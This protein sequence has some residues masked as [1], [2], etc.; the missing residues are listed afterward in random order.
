METKSVGLEIKTIDNL[1]LRRILNE[2]KGE[3]SFVKTPYQAII[4]KYLVT[5]QK[6]KVYQHTLEK[7][8]NLRRSTISGILDTMEKKGTI[9][10][11]NSNEDARSKLVVLTP[12]AFEVA[13]RHLAKAKEFDAMMVEGINEND[14]EVFYKVTDKI[15]ENLKEKENV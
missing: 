8:L 6:N 3:E 13:S 5:N 9:K 11:I 7:E 14:L 4:F 12:K 1:I 2:A 15:I 10:R